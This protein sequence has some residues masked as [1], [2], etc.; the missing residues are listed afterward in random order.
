MIAMIKPPAS[1]EPETEIEGRGR[2]V[3][4]VPDN[5][6]T[7]DVVSLLKANLVAVRNSIRAALPAI[8]DNMTRNHLQDVSDRIEHAMEIK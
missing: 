7:S 1:A 4:A 2:N 3:R 8:N 5:S 6:R